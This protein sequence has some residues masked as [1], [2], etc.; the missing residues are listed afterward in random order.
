MNYDRVFVIGD[1]HGC[2]DMLNRLMDKIPWRPDNDL[3]IFLG[4]YI[5]RGENSKKV[6]DY[7]I[8][9][10]RFSLYVK[11]LLG[12]HDAMFLDY[13]HNK[14]VDQYLLNGGGST[15]KSYGIDH[16][17][18]GQSLIPQDH[19][20]F[21][22][23]LKSYI[24][25]EDYYIVHAGFRPGIEI[26]KQKLKDMLWIRDTFINSHY[27]FGKKVIFGHTPLMEP[28][29][30]KNKIGLDTSAVFGNRLTC[31]ELPKEKFYSVAQ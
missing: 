13:L 23:T 10:T 25:L 3:L 21:F 7:I 12:N 26:S 27:D 2:L 15:L 30:S 8:A 24:D 5:D 14:N 28:L 11:C 18:E 9:L 17:E 1:I 31:L 4:D 6:V 29:V 20:D 16:P 22:K 19:F